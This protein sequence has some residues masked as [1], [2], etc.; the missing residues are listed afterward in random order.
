MFRCGRLDRGDERDVNKETWNSLWDPE[1]TMRNDWINA[2]LGQGRQEMGKLKVQSSGS[3]G[4]GLIPR[5]QVAQMEEPREVV[6]RV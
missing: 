5:L 6:S 2:W 4:G 1:A 3:A